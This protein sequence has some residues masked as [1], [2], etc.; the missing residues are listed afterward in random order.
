M[1][2]APSA[3]S[4]G[5]LGNL[6]LKNRMIKA[7]TFEGMT[8]DGEPGERLIEFHR[9]IAAGGVAMTTVAY[10]TTE[11]DGR[12]DEHMMYLDE[13]FAPVLGSL[14]DA[15]HK[16][17]ARVSGQI[18]HCGNFSKNRRL[19]RL[20]RPL[21]PSRQ[22]N[23]LGLPAGLPFAGAMSHA[24]I[25]GLVD[26]YARAG[27]FMKRTGFDA[28][29]IH[30]GHGYGLSQFLSAKTNRRSDEYGGSLSNRLRLPL[31][32]LE[33][34]RRSVGDDFPLLGKISMSDGVKGG[35][36]WQEGLEIA[37]ALDRG[38]LDAIVT[39]GGTSSF[40][41]MLMFRGTSIAKSM[42]ET[43]KNPLMRAGLKLLGPSMFRDYGY[44]ELYFLERAQ[45]VRDRVDCG[46]V[47]I[48]GCS[49]RQSLDRVFSAGFDFVQLGRPLLIDP[50]FPKNARAVETYDSGCTHCNTCVG[51]IDHPDGIHCPFADT[52]R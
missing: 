16:A 38:G 43:E 15:V 10:C 47:Y 18:T 17:G 20:K 46:V 14:I 26:S 19:Q 8:P 4:P 7:A 39:S 37:A 12:I 36:S 11:P 22:I 28:A 32:V 51:L 34:V 50:D 44:E 45:A 25:D 30:F 13:R 27:A 48:G 9:R 41:P 49:T 5:Q 24:D 6:E 2:A 23:M 29:E 33:A 1:T 52:R 42:I 35:V 40:N 3:F 21:G 31:R